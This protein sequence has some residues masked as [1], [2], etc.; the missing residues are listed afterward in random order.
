[1][2]RFTIRDLALLTVLAAMGIA[3]WL[4]HGRIT[5]LWQNAKRQ[6]EHDRWAAELLVEESR[7]ETG[8]VRFV[9]DRRSPTVIIVGR[10]FPGGHCFSTYQYPAMPEP[11]AVLDSQ[12]ADPLPDSP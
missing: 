8:P 2:L 4:D 7:R 10:Y 12:G 5:S 6:G 9:A 11:I 3:W 1:M